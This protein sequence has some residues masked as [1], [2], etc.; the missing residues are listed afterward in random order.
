MLL[1]KI[2]IDTSIIYGEKLRTKSKE[3]ELHVTGGSINGR[4]RM[5]LKIQH[6]DFKNS[7]YHLNIQ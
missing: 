1:L 5:S 2:K 3:A 6:F 7:F 4:M